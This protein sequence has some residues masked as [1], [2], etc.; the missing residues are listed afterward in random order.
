MEHLN[1][2]GLELWKLPRSRRPQWGL[3]KTHGIS[4]RR[5]R[6]LVELQR[7]VAVVASLPLHNRAAS[8]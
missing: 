1:G 3:I 8:K 5:E 7:S 6:R 2:T 4:L